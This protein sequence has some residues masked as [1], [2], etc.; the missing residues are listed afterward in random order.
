M[1]QHLNNFVVYGY[2]RELCRVWARV[3]AEAEKRGRRLECADGWIAATA[4]SHGI[5]LLT[6]NRQHF[7]GVEGLYVISEASQR[8]EPLP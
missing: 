8:P 5:P 6:H 7:E 4:I 2:Q 1:E 3:M